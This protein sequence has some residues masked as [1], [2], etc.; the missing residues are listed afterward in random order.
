VVVLMTELARG[1]VEVVEGKELVVSFVGQWVVS[2]EWKYYAQAQTQSVAKAP[3]TQSV[4]KAP[5]TQSVAK[6]PPLQLVAPQF[7]PQL[8]SLQRLV[9]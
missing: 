4:A 9:V 2:V 7:R 8:P 6:A 1:I 3:Q 5:Q